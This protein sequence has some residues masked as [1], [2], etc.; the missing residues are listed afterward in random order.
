MASKTISKKV[1][2]G[3][4]FSLVS[5]IISESYAQAPPRTCSRTGPSC[6]NECDG[7]LATGNY[8][9][10]GGC[11]YYVTC[12]ATSIYYIN[13]PSQTMWNDFLKL[14]TSASNT[15]TEC[16]EDMPTTPEDVT[17]TT[18][19]VTPPVPALCESTGPFCI[20]DCTNTVVGTY[21]WCARCDYFLSCSGSANYWRQCQPGLV[22]DH[23]SIACVYPPSSTCTQCVAATTTT[24]YNPCDPN[25][26]LNG[27]TCIDGDCECTDDY[28]GP[29]CGTP[30]PCFPNPCLNGGTCFNNGQ[31]S[32]PPG[33]SGIFCEIRD[34]CIPN[35]CQNGGTCNN[36]LC[37]CL[38]GYIGQNC[39][40]PD[41]CSPNPC[42][43]GG[44]CRNGVC[45]CP[46]GYSGTYCEIR[47][48]C[49]PNPCQNGGSCNNGVC[50]CLPGYT[51]PYCTDP[52][53]EHCVPN[54]CINGECFDDGTGWECFCYDGW[55]G[56][57]CENRTDHCIPDPCFNGGTCVNQDVGYIC[58]CPGGFTGLRCEQPIDIDPINGTCG[59][60][61]RTAP[62]YEVI[63]SGW[64]NLCYITSNDTAYLGY[65]C[66]ALLQ[67]LPVVGNA[68]GLL[69]YGGN[70]GCWL[71]K[72]YPNPDLQGA[73]HDD[74]QHFHSIN[75]N[76]PTCTIF[77]V[78]LRYP[79]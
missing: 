36:G 6:I 67:D 20:N 50:I 12:V 57:R 52:I 28:I 5:L 63:P 16:T 19:L 72:V 18:T 45:S 15:C 32:C 60:I 39:T 9:W 78:C 17:A 68:H 49:T 30:N 7:S 61:L 47:D 51:G 42:L 73:C 58:I 35:P 25:P 8:Q 21:Q 40:E 69:V 22:Y 55:T 14:C 38:P 64:T 71:S 62:S 13:C 59:S 27:G 3:I 2:L 56:P 11:S 41:P 48:P 79:R 4:L 34:P 66:E 77:A 29:D 37:I 65:E 1:T 44:T 43:N 76:C 70:Y 53:V 74:Y 46:P 31:C 26:C 24:A 75:A 54:P 33:Y 23:N 10:C